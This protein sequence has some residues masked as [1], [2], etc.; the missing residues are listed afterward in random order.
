MNSH[1]EIQIAT[2]SRFGER[3]DL[4]RSWQLAVAAGAG[5]LGVGAFGGWWSAIDDDNGDGGVYF[6]FSIVLMLSA[7]LTVA[8]AWSCTK[9]TDRRTMRVCGLVFGVIAVAST[10]VAW[11]G[12]LWM[13]TLAISLGVSAAAAPRSMRPGLTGIAVGHILG[14]VVAIAAVEAKVGRQDSYGDYPV[15]LDLGVLAAAAGTVVG[16]ALVARAARASESEW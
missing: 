8:A 14:I 6:L 1:T 12:P 2:A 5:W 4:V 9:A 16:L 3:A 10:V 15:A 11:A 7:V 13:T